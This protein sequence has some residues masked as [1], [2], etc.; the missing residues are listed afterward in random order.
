MRHG[1]KEGSEQG[2][3]PIQ[4]HRKPANSLLGCSYMYI[5]R[6]SIK[7]YI[8]AHFFAVLT[9]EYNVSSN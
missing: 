7:A 8:L 2:I 4:N 1:V 5:G 9:P 6:I 3:Y